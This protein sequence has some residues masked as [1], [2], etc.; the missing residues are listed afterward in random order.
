MTMPDSFFRTLTPAEEEEFRQWARDNWKPGD[1]VNGLWHPV[2]RDEIAHL[3]FLA[4]DT[5]GGV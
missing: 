2:V 1:E 3:R 4:G 5:Q